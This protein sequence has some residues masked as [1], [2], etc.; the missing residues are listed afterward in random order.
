MQLNVQNI[1]RQRKE[2]CFLYLCSP[3]LVQ[4]HRHQRRGS[5]LADG[6]VAALPEEVAALLLSGPRRLLLIRFLSPPN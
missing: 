1:D 4:L 5:F 3:L 2:T 6:G